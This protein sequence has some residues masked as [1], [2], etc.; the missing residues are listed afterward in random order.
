MRISILDEIKKELKD[1]QQMNQSKLNELKNNYY[2]K[3]YLK[4]L[5]K[6]E[7]LSSDKMVLDKLEEGYDGTIFGP[8]YSCLD[9]SCNSKFYN[10]T[11]I[12]T[13]II[14]LKSFYQLSCETNFSEVIKYINAAKE[15]L[16]DMKYY[17]GDALEKEYLGLEIYENPKNYQFADV[18]V[19]EKTL[20]KEDWKTHYNASNY[21]S[22][23]ETTKQFV[24]IKPYSSIFNTHQL[25][26]R[27]QLAFYG[28]LAYQALGIV[29]SDNNRKIL[30]KEGK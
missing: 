7:K 15:I 24:M 21:I 23:N 4:E 9:Q 26:E 2:V 14:E 12:V 17:V 8:V 30:E 27:E 19:I 18:E 16:H 25:T 3:K 22:Y 11:M 28:P 10:L 6:Q 5:K 29:A 13:R 20:T 1:H